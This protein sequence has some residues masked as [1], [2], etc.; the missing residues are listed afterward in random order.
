MAATT[1]L[2]TVAEFEKLIRDNVRLEL[3]HGEVITLPPAKM[4]HNRAEKRLVRALESRIG[5][6]GYV[7]SEVPFR[8]LPEHEVWTADVAFLVNERDHGTAGDDWIAG[9]PDLVA[10]ILSPSN[11]AEEMQEREDVCL[12]NGSRQFWS[13]S[14]DRRSVKVISVSG[15]V[16][17]YRPGDEIDLAEFGGCTLPVSEIFSE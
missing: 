14:L 5:R 8:P 7:N 4:R 1:G 15:S 6:Y 9:A 11:T 16:R 12:R 2:I 17:T 3:H 10:E 13:V